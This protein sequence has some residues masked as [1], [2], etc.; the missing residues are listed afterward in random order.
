[1][2]KQLKDA[3]AKILEEARSSSRKDD[4]NVT[5]LLKS[6]ILNKSFDVNLDDKRLPNSLETDISNT[7]PHKMT[8]ISPFSSGNF[9]NTSLQTSNTSLDLNTTSYDTPNPEPPVNPS[10][11]NLCD[12]MALKNLIKNSDIIKQN[13]DI[14]K[15]H[16]VVKPINELVT[17]IKRGPKPK[18]PISKIVKGPSAFLTSSDGSCPCKLKAMAMC[19]QCESYW[20]GDCINSEQL[21]VLCT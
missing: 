4:D 18:R 16:E 17:Q 10:V 6:K 15:Q 11:I 3:K 20:H 1:M 21:C 7:S 13:N 14:N 19:V 8:S 9:Y 12:N 5:N 2:D